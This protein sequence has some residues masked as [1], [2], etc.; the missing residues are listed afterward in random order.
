MALMNVDRDDVIGVFLFLAAVWF[1]LAIFSLLIV[2][3][4][5]AILA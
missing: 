5:H 2:L 3:W 1:V 4:K